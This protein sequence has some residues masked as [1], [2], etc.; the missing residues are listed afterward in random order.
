EP[1]QSIEREV[2]AAVRSFDAADPSASVP[3]LARGL[4]ATR[5]AL[6]AAAKEP[7]AAFLLGIKERQFVDA[8]NT[9]LGLELTAD[10]QAAGTTEPTG[11]FAAFAPPP[12][13][14]APVPGQS[15]E[16]VARLTNRGR[17]PITP[18][19]ITLSAPRGW[20]VTPSAQPLSP[21]ESNA[22]LRFRFAVTLAEDAPLSSRPYFTRRSVQE[23]RYEVIDPSS[24]H[25]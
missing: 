4:Q 24:R 15:F 10:A 3:A 11:P 25:R 23:N 2:E 6:G 12:S 20:T 19:Q 21:L 17:M 13:F 8:I 18:T 5:L 7:D 14:A 22:G 16:V 1:L 9:A